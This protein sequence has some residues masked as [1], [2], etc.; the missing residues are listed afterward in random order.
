MPKKARREEVAGDAGKTVG[1][2]CLVEDTA[3]KFVQLVGRARGTDVAWFAEGE[4]FRRSVEL[5]KDVEA[6][7]RSVDQGL[8]D[9]VDEGL[10]HLARAEG[11]SWD[12]SLGQLE[13]AR[14][15]LGLEILGAWNT[16]KNL[17]PQ[18]ASSVCFPNID[19]LHWQ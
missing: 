12:V 11:A 5:C 8:R 19:A 10:R 15:V 16:Q 2:S 3:R 13:K 14:D 1:G 6:A 17:V 4:N 9:A 7:A 18:V